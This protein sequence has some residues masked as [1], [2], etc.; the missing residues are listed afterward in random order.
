MMRTLFTTRA[1]PFYAQADLVEIGLLSGAAVEEIVATGFSSTGRDPGGLAGIIHTFTSGHPQRAM[2]LADA[3]WR[4]TPLGATADADVW[5]TALGEVRLAAAEGMERRYSGFGLGERDV[6]RA[7]A[8]W[9]SV[10]GAEADLLGLS[11]GTANSRPGEPCSTAVTCS[12]TTL[13]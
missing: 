8:L 4:Y 6:L 10:Y 9:G 12:K 7:V 1:E 11:K 2:Q 3:C 13:D 5:S